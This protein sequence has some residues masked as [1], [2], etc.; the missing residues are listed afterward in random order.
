MTHRLSE[1]LDQLMT[2]DYI[3]N[4]QFLNPVYT[5]TLKEI[6]EVFQDVDTLKINRLLG[7]CLNQRYYDL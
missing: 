5:N 1:L 7:I 6:N 2:L 3:Q 4:P